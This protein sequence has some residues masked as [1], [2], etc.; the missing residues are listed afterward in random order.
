MTSGWESRLGKYRPRNYGR[1]RRSCPGSRRA[2]AG[3]RRA[4]AGLRRAVAGL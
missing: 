3:L 2:V 4:V 1:V